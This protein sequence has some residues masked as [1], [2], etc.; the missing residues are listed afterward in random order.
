MYIYIYR[1]TRLSVTPGHRNQS[2]RP[3]R[4]WLCDWPHTHSHTHTHCHT[5]THTH[6]H[7]HART[8]ARTHAHT[9]THTH[10]HTHD[11]HDWHDTD[12][13]TVNRIAWSSE[14]L[15]MIWL[16]WVHLITTA[17][18]ANPKLIALIKKKNCQ[19]LM[20]RQHSEEESVEIS[21]RI[22]HSRDC[23]RI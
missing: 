7:T 10:T 3:G 13:D 20:R 2:S 22:N 6:T 15:K 1:K 14:I 5:H 19:T 17:A 12:T 9:H 16:M 21:D 18:R 11:W 8:H 4:P 23:T